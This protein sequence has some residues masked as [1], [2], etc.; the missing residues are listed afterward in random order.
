MNLTRIE[1]SL[2]SNCRS[3]LGRAVD[4]WSVLNNIKNGLTREPI[5]RIRHLYEVE[6]KRT[7]DH[8]KA[9]KAVEHLKK[10]LPAVPWSGLFSRRGNE[11]LIQYS[12]LICVDL[13]LLGERLAEVREKLK[14]SLYLFALFLSPTADGLKAIFRVRPDPSKHFGSFAA[15]QQHVLELTGVQ[16]DESGKDLARLCFVS[17]DPEAYLNPNA[18]EIPPRLVVPGNQTA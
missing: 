11:A 15:H 18:Q 3:T 17:F 5:A 7:G 1:I 14:A 4:V 9:K 8:R 6:L 2:F 13:D 12:G 16:I 10:N